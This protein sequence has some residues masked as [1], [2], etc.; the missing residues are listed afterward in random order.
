[1]SLV[2]IKAEHNKPL[3]EDCQSDAAVVTLEY[4]SI[5]EFLKYIERRAFHMARL[6][7][8]SLDD[9]HDIVQE[10]MY[11]LVEKYADKDHRAWK[12][13]FY[14][15]LNSK[16]TDYYRRNTVKDRL[17]PWK[18]TDIEDAQ[19]Y[20]NTAV[21]QGIARSS[22]EPDAMMIRQQNTAKL[23][24]HIQA[25]AR[26]QKQAFILRTWEGLSTRETAKAMGC[27]EGSVKTHYS[28]AM[29][30]LRSA[31]KEDYND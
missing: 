1:M 10:S 12:P 18:K 7:T 20:F 19:D 21:E 17:F 13:L 8:R 28:R 30:R 5:D 22:E 25:L 9:A 3:S 26:R 4:N 6:S 29:N 23:A 27:S 14:R 16:I 11:K 15:I 31:L 2:H 24:S